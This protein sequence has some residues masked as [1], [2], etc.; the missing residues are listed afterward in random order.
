MRSRAIQKFHLA[1]VLLGVGLMTAVPAAGAAE[2][3]AMSAA[4]IRAL[5][6][7]LTDA[8]CYAGPVD[9]TASE[10][11]QAALKRCPSMDPVLA[12]ETGMHTAGINRVG[13]DRECRLLATGSDDKTV[14]LWSLPEGRL[15]RTLR[16]PIGPGSHGKVYAVASRRTAR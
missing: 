14:R 9:G 4:D 3:G 8:Q 7:R 16:P 13:V 10:A 2:L 6:Q 15:I 11:T 1:A 5:Q 12:I